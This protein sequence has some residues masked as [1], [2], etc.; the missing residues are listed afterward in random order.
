[1]LWY[2]EGNHKKNNS[3]S[4][5]YT[6]PLSLQQYVI[7][8]HIVIR[9]NEV[10]SALTTFFVLKKKGAILIDPQ[11]IFLWNINRSTC[12][13]PSCKIEIKLFNKK[14]LISITRNKPIIDMDILRDSFHNQASGFTQID[15]EMK[16]TQNY[17][18]LV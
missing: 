14:L 15:S 13:D 9:I 3:K 12:L 11:T 2:Q 10:M 5:C 4:F 18:I 17:V 1:V 7:W 16:L 8:G 6:I